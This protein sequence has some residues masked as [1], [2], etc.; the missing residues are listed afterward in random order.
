MAEFPEG[1]DPRVGRSVVPWTARPTFNP[2]PT[3]HRPEDRSAPS[4]APRG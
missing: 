4:R 1:Y 2:V 3:R